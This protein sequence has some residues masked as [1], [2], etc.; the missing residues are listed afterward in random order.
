[1]TSPA[2]AEFTCTSPGWAASSTSGDALDV[3]NRSPVDVW[4]DCTGSCHQISL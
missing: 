3:Y 1:M 4:A 2:N